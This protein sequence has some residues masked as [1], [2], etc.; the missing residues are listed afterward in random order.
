M[1]VKGY[2]RK[3]SWPNLRYSTSGFLEGLRKTR[4]AW[5]LQHSMFMP[6]NGYAL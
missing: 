3:R 5:E 2:G 6:E 4:N 1:S